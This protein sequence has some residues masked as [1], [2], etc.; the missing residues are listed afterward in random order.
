[1]REKWRKI[2]QFEHTE[3]KRMISLTGKEVE[4]DEG[5][6]NKKGRCTHTYYIYIYIYI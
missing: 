6:K 5:N 1:M 4:A 3:C 2:R